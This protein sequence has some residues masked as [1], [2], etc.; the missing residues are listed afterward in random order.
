[1]PNC[2][3]FVDVA[4]SPVKIAKVKMVAA[5]TLVRP[6]RSASGPRMNDSPQSTRNGANRIDPARSTFAGVDSKPE[7][8]SSSFK[9][10]VNTSA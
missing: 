8:G 7:R 4:A 6:K 2:H 5:S 9:A 1:M 3:T 10:G